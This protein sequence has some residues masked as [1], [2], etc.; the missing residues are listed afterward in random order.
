[1]PCS[2]PK[3]LLDR[4]VRESVEVRTGRTGTLRLVSEEALK[5]AAAE[6]EGGGP[7][8]R[9][10]LELALLA[11]GVLPRRYL[12]NVDSL[13][14][15]GQARLLRARVGVA[16]LGGL[17]G[18]VSELLARAGV[19]ELVLVDPDVTSDDNLN[20][21]LLADEEN[22][23][24]PKVDAA[25]VRLGAVNSATRVTAFRLRGDADSFSRVFQGAAVVVDCLD[26]IPARFAL[27]DAA[28]SLG[29]PLVH[30][31]VGGFAGH[32]TCVFPGDPGLEALYGP[33]AEAA[34]QGVESVVGTPSPTPAVVAALEVT[35]VLKIIAGV[36]EPLRRKLLT[37][38]TASPYFA[39]VEL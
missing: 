33:R 18:L 13:G 15:D 9:R 20:R 27:E 34:A 7:A 37:F 19:G 31:A 26:S 16:G 10:D 6:G 8:A 4:L 32:V 11:R 3:H 39:V 14:L 24:R 2:V 22:L 35:E 38:D 12:R 23:G 21:Q 1:M 5:A 25:A 30:G 36:G 29:V 17:G 28:R